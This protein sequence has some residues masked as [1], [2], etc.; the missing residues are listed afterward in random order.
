[1]RATD[2]TASWQI[3]LQPDA[4]EVTRDVHDN[5]ADLSID[6]P[7]SDLYLLLWNRRGL[8]GLDFTGDEAV[9]D[10]WQEAVRVRWT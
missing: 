7:A 6:A 10:A 5:G 4:V 8:A 2:A 1:V 3:T 9:L